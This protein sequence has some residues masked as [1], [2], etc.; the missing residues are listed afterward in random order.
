MNPQDF[1]KVAVLMGGLSGERQV[2]LKSG[3]AVLQALKRKHV[4]AYGVDADR[5][6]IQVLAD[7]KFDRAFIALHG[8]WGEDGVIQGALELLGLPYT[9][10]RVL[11]SALGMDKLRCKRLWA[12]AGIQTAEYIELHADTDLDEIEHWLGFPVFVKPNQEGSSLGIS[13]ARSVTELAVAWKAAHEFD[14]TVFVERCIEGGE[15]TVTILNGE[16]LPAI[17]VETPR[18]FYDYQAKYHEN[19]TRYLCPCGLPEPAEKALQQIALKAFDAVGCHG[20]GRVDFMVSKDGAPYALE[21]NTV[22]GMTDHSLVPMAAKYAGIGFDDL[23]YRIL[24]TSHV[25]R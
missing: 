23:V 18:E 16:A 20:W 6:V 9:G 1:G 13:K 5:R 12:T 24:E 3:E 4:D 17:K 25:D 15:Y 10:S 19:T 14:D 22:P 2:S 11:A 7:G 8:R 21:V